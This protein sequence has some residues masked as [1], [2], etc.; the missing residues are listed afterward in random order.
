MQFEYDESEW[1]E[2]QFIKLNHKT[3]EKALMEYQK[4][5]ESYK[6]KFKMHGNE[7]ALKVSEMFS[8]KMS[9]FQNKEWIIRYLTIEVMTRKM[10][11]WDDLFAVLEKPEME[12]V[13]DITLRYLESI[14]VLEQ[15]SKI[16]EFS[17]KM[18][19]QY[20]LEKKYI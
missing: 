9:I 5:N 20:D 13:S 14:G 7:H 11:L 19:K 1:S 18:E 12:Y 15:K 16:I 8:Q 17:F 4:Q 3:I 6:A 10:A 2:S